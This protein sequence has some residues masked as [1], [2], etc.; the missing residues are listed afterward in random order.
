MLA[1]FIAEG[2]GLTPRPGRWQGPASTMRRR[3]VG[4]ASGRADL[5]RRGAH[6]QV[7]GLRG[8]ARRRALARR[9]PRRAARSARR[10]RRWP[11]RHRPLPVRR[12]S[13]SPR[14]V[15]GH[16]DGPGRPRP[17]RR[18]RRDARGP[19]RRRR[20]R[21]GTPRRADAGESQGPHRSVLQAHEAIGDLL[22]AGSGE[23]VG[24]AA[25]GDEPDR[26]AAW[27]ASA[28]AS[29]REPA[30]AP[31][32]RSG[33]VGERTS[34]SVSPRSPGCSGRV[35][36]EQCRADHGLAG[37]RLGLRAGSSCR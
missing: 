19:R 24:E 17:A 10:A 30:A 13:S 6:R 14:R 3:G 1:T 33:L 31:S 32:R 23:G 11:A 35:L 15:A 27:S 36:G 4:V 8:S 26:S 25:V 28:P 22:G 20:R 29:G 12:G 7:H 5:L 2:Y 16:P 37:G 18:P 34:S 9:R 21:A